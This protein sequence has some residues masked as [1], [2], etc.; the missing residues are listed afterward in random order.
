[1]TVLEKDLP[2]LVRGMISSGEAKELLSSCTDWSG[3][4]S[5]QWKARANA[6]QAALDSGDP[7]Q[8]VKVLKGLAHLET[9]GTLRSSDR[10]HMNQSLDL[11]LEELSCALKQSRRGVRKLLDQAVGVPV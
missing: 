8:Y 3:K 1:M 10:S 4:P 2:N 9:T 7:F 5:N 11:L 6:H